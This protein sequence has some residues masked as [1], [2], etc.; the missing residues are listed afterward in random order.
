MPGRNP[1]EDRPG[2][3]RYR[4]QLDRIERK[5]TLYSLLI[6]VLVVVLILFI[7]RRL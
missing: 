2:G 5:M 6:V 4:A 7:A 1:F 3:K